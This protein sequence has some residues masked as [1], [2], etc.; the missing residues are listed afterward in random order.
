MEY[1][2]AKPTHSCLECG[3]ELYGR[4]DKQFCDMNCKNHYYNRKAFILRQAVTDLKEKLSRNHQILEMLIND[5]TVNIS[6]SAIE[7]LG[8]DSR[9]NSCISSDYRG[10]R[11]YHCLNITYYMSKNKIYGLKYTS[12]TI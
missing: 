12:T 6:L 10:R 4:K 2:I 9:Y 3:T 5:K 8:F 1:K 7:Q 11:V